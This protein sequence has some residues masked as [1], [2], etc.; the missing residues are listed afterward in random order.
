[1]VEGTQ[2][3]DFPGSPN[4]DVPCALELTRSS[5]Q[6]GHHVTACTRAT[7]TVSIEEPVYGR[8]SVSHVQVGER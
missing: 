7:L 1:M 5:S 6:E 2:T 4:P 8:S 3:R